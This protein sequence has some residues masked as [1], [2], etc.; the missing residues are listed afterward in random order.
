MCEGAQRRRAEGRNSPGKIKMERVA[1]EQGSME[2]S[3][4]LEVSGAEP[5]GCASLAANSSSQRLSESAIFLQSP[6][7]PSSHDGAP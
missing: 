5:K 4:Q 6:V 2:T 3:C 1:V 7:G